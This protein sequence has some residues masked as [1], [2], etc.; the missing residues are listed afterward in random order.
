[1]GY[2]CKFVENPSIVLQ[3]QCT[4]CLQ[5]LR[6][7]HQAN[8]CGENFCKE[9]I[10][11]VKAANQACP[12]CRVKDFPLFHDKALQQR[13]LYNFRVY[14]THKSEGCEWTGELKEIDKHLNSDHMIALWYIICQV[15][16][17]MGWNRLF[18]T[19]FMIIFN[20]IIIYSPPCA[21]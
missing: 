17:K 9:C 19:N 20:T 13:E 1:M 3:F 16:L 4:I 21:S 6:E 7:P 14:C 5:V 12:T 15:T 8:C 11:R 2:D 18:A 10:H